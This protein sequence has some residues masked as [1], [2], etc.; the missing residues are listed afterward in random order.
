[1][2]DRVLRSRLIRLAHTNAE[3]RPH[4]L[5][6]LGK[7][8]SDNEFPLR[9][10][11]VPLKGWALGQMKMWAQ[12]ANRDVVDEDELISIPDLQIESVED[13]GDWITY[14]IQDGGSFAFSFI[15]D[16][17]KGVFRIQS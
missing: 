10:L 9:G 16:L 2:E 11:G 14:D 4:L 7:Q 6:L 15:L 1:M 8:A 3:L 17:R 12:K 13:R 5:P